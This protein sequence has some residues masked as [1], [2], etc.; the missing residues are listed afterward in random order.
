V[1]KIE[2]IRARTH[3][4]PE[5]IR[6]HLVSLL[7]VLPHLAVLVRFQLWSVF[8]AVYELFEACLLNKIE[9]S[10]TG[11]FQQRQPPA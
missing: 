8:R 5:F 10:A 6:L 3:S 2:T 11:I 4:I 9:S 1:K 7:H